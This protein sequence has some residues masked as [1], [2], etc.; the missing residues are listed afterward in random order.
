[1]QLSHRITVLFIVGKVLLLSHAAAAAFTVP[2]KRL[3]VE[4]RQYSFVHPVKSS[5]SS[6]LTLSSSLRS[7][8]T[9][10]NGTSTVAE[11]LTIESSKTF[12]NNKYQSSPPYIAIITER[13]SCDN[14]RN[15]HD[16]LNA[17]HESVQTNLVNLISIRVDAS[18]HFNSNEYDDDR[19][20]RSERLMHMIHTL[21]EWSQLYNNFIVVTSSDW[22]E[23]AIEAGIHGI[24]FKETHRHLIPYARELRQKNQRMQQQQQSHP[25]IVG[26]STHT[27]HSAIDAWERYGPI[28]YY[29][30]G[31]CFLT[32]SH[33]EKA[34]SELEGPYFPGR[35]KL[36]LSEHIT[37]QS[38]KD[39]D[40]KVP[41]VLA[42][43]GIDATN[44]HI[45]FQCQRDDDYNNDNSKTHHRW[46][47]SS[48]VDGIATI[49]AVFKSSDP[50]YAVRQIHDNMK[51]AIETNG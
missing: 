37:R 6:W 5:S 45:P 27:I 39:V 50:A 3:F 8:G 11:N 12:S 26:T 46:S 10:V 48:R 24:H 31:T 47:S 1:M 14:D 35:V 21:L 9:N 20:C 51:R 17:I 44:C 18:I 29:I 13:T 41:P 30:A 43:G 33:P 4:R 42:I 34:E 36:A 49:R 23:I 15:M 22:I 32:E 28:D 2:D 40:T 19:K 16:A 7:L 38:S 25:L